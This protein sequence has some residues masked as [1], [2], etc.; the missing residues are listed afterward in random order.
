MDQVFADPSG[1]A[2]YVRQAL[3]DGVEQVGN[4][5]GD[6][7]TGGRINVNNSLQLI[8]NDCGSC[9]TPLRRHR[10]GD[11]RGRGDVLLEQHGDGP[12]QRAVPPG[13][14]QHPGE[15]PHAIN[16][17][18]QGE[19]PDAC[20]AYEFQVEAP[21]RH[22]HERL[23]PSVLLEPPVEPVPTITLDNEEVF[24]EGDQVTLTSSAATNLW[25]TGETTA[26]IVVT[27]QAPTPWMVWGFVTRPVVR[28]WTSSCWTSC[29]PPPTT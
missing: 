27:R 14:H 18:V 4:P 15:L 24:C 26:S 22:H 7:V 21:V 2:L 29:C 1:A 28:P 3:F 9:P 10:G 20:T 8:M 25:S 13:R 17:G 23:G 11:G 12:V 5:P 6:L 19:R 16:M